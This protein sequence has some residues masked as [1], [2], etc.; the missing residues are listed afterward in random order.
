[1]SDNNVI[2]R[3]TVV[4]SAR[5]YLRPMI[6]MAP[7]PLTDAAQA[8]VSVVIHSVSITFNKIG[9]EAIMRPTM[10]PHS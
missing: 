5:F 9:A 3:R 4:L 10:L 8:Q 2:R 1:M 7:E 6:P